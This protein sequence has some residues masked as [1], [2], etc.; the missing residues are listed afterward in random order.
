MLQGPIIHQRPHENPALRYVGYGEHKL[1]YF[2]PHTTRTKELTPRTRTPYRSPYSIRAVSCVLHC[3]I[4][5]SLPRH[6]PYEYGY[7]YDIPCTYVCTDRIVLLPLLLWWW[8]WLWRRMRFMRCFI[9]IATAGP[10]L[11][12]SRWQWHA[13]SQFTSPSLSRSLSLSLSP[14]SAFTYH[15]CCCC[16]CYCYHHHRHHRHHRHHTVELNT[17]LY[18]CTSVVHIGVFPHVCTGM[19]SK[20]TR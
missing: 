11:F 6:D 20:T 9:V 7:T 1:V 16:C 12:G 2:E 18:K 19:W 17:R 4:H 10:W 15:C 13:V 14:M 3:S 8:L 5:Y